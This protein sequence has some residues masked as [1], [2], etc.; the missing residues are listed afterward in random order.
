MRQIWRR[1]TF[2]HWPYAPDVIRGFIP[3]GL[4]LDAFD[5]AA[6]VGLVPF[7]I[8]DTPGIPYFPETNLRTYVIGP[9]GAR[10]VW[11]FSLEAA[12]LAAVLGARTAYHLAYFWAKM[13]VSEENGSIHYE[14]RR[15]GRTKLTQ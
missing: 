1:L 14:S 10:A 6:W 15:R 13:L 3:P 8:H 12:N 11:F 4:E 5:N 2:L 7:E 9:D